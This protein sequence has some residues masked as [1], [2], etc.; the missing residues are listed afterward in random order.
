MIEIAIEAMP[1]PPV[2]LRDPSVQ[3][4]LISEVPSMLASDILPTCK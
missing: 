2:D 3:D 4:A 1:V